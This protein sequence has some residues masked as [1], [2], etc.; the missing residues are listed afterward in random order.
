MMIKSLMRDNQTLIS[1]KVAMTLIWV[2][3]QIGQ[4]EEAGK[5]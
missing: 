3:R 2:E 4:K 5:G 1:A